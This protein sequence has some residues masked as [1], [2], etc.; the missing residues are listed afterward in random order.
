MIELIKIIL[1]YPFLNLLTFYVWLVPGHHVIWGI[2]LLTLTVRLILL[3]PTKRQ[4]QSQRK[5]MQL[6]PLIE[7]LKKEYGEDKQGLAAAQMELYKNNG[8]N[9]FGSCLLA[10]I[11]LPIL[12]ILYYAIL[13]GITGETAH[14]YIWLPRPSTIQSIFLGIDL[15]K[16]DHTYILPII[17][18][19]LQF[20]QMKLVMPKFAPG[21]KVDPT[22]SMQKNM[23]YILPIMTLVIAGRFPGGV[24]VYW[25]ISTGFS[26]VQQY[27]VNQEKFKIEGVEKVMKEADKE[28]PEY[29]RSEAAEKK[30]LKEAA[31]SK[32]GVTVTVRKKTK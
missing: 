12:L 30:I 21:A 27:F 10:V 16:P 6:A 29:H 15:L 19:G 7:D 25:I 11:Q 26:V 1:Y 5:T 17:A 13:H 4:A 20:L 31:V 18:A 14:L 3:I 32:K 23:A 8:I 24:A 22:V 9:P 2:I 28:H